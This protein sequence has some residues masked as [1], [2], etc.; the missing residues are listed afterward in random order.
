[1]RPVGADDDPRGAGSPASPSGSSDASSAPVVEVDRGHRHPRRT[2]AP[3]AAASSSSDRV[4]PRPVEPDRRLAARRRR[5]RS[6]GRS[7]R[8][9][10]RRASP[11]SAGRPSA[12]S[13]RVQ[14]RPGAAP[15]TAA[16]DANTPPARHCQAGERSRTT[17]GWPDRG[18]PGGERRPGRSAAD[19][20]DAQPLGGHPPGPDRV[21]RRVRV[22]KPV[23]RRLASAAPRSRSAGPNAPRTVLTGDQPGV[24][25]QRG[26]LD[27]AGT[28]G[29]R[30]AARRAGCSDCRSAGGPSA[31]PRSSRA[32]CARGR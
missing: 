9:A 28:P 18:Q 6:G 16:G 31:T 23:A 12:N 15:T 19:D 17:T 2:S 7:C 27:R 5:R 26:H 24:A 4:E 32:G 29:G 30:T 8:P 1:M 3:A 25:Q 10:S 14:S 13:R 22:V 11:G 20:R 21:G